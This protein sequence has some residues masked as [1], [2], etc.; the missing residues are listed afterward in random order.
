MA[1]NRSDLPFPAVF[2]LVL[3]VQLPLWLIGG[4]LW[5]L[6]M[7]LLARTHPVNALIGGLTWGIC[8]WAVMGTLMA[9]GLAW[10]RSTTFPVR[11][12]ASF[13]AAVDEACRRSLLIVVAEA[14]D[15]IILGPKWTLVRFRLQESVLA[16]EGDRAT[17]TASALAFS[18]I[19][20]RLQKAL[21]AAKVST[22]A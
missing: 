9:A 10:R 4:L 15:R 1:S 5:A 21:T 11:D 3:L 18:S 20:K 22:T 8:M 13:R 14:P 7:A 6:L 16:F 17:L 12:R 19:R 2:L